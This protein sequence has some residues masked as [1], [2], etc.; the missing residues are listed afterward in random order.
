MSRLHGQ[1]FW[2]TYSVEH[3][4]RRPETIVTWCTISDD[5]QRKCHS[6][7]MANERDQIKVGYETV[8]IT[9]K[10]ATNKEEC[11][12]LLDQES[13]TMVTL[14]AGSVFVGGR[15][16]SLVPIAE[17][18]LDGGHNYYFSVAVIKKGSLDDVV[19][20]HQ[21]RGKKAC[22]PGVETFAGW[23]VP[24]NTLMKEG[25][26]E[27]VDCNN[28][29]KSAT[30]YFGPSCSVNCLSDKY[31][32]IGDNSDKL[33][34]LCIGK[35]PGGRCTDADPYAGYEGAF[36]C[37]LEAGEIA[38]L[39]HNSVP[40]IIEKLGFTGLS[41]DS[42]EL[43]CKDGSR[44][45]ISDYLAC[46]WGKV[47][48]DAVVVSSATS[49]EIRTKLQKFLEKFSKKYPKAHSNITYTST[50]PSNFPYGGNQYNQQQYDQFGNRINR[51]K[52]QDYGTNYGRDESTPDPFARDPYVLNPNQYGVNIDPYDRDVKYNTGDANRDPYDPYNRDP[53]YD[54]RDSNEYGGN[55]RTNGTFYEN[56]SLFESVPRYG[57]RSNL[58]FQD[59]ARH[60]APLPENLQT[61]SSFLGPAL[62]TIMGVRDCPVNRMILC[63]T[64]DAEK[65]KCVKMRTALKSQLLK[66]EM[67]CYKGHSQIHCMQAIRSG[68]ADVA[69]FDAGDIYTAGLNFEL[70]PFISEVY[71]LDEPEYYVVAVAKESDPSTELTYLKNKNTCHGGINTAAGWVYPLAF[72]I[73]NGWIRPYG[74]NS[75]RAAAEYFAKSCVPGAISTEYNTGVPYDNMCDLCHGAS[76]R[77]CRRDASEDYYGHTGA[78]RCLVEGGG[79]VAFV[80]HTTVTENTGG[81]KREWWARDNLNDDYELLCPDGTRAEI[82]E[83]KRCN[84]GKVKANAIIARGGYGYNETHINAYIN[85]FMYAQTL[86]GKKSTDEFSFSMYSSPAPY[87][88]LIFQDATTQLKMIEPYK[89]HYAEYLGSDFLRAKRVVDCHAG[90]IG[91]SLSVTTF[92]I[93]LVTFLL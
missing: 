18:V 82:H 28:H 33:C 14:D 61:F 52:R 93:C 58:L 59:A 22:F 84:L 38:F 78:F 89:R 88:D 80:K 10:Q 8:N 90:S 63:V 85:L 64:S 77:Y 31:N 20:L 25:G 70:V 69:V 30:N 42:F 75:I 49:F 43:L 62:D 32:P 53:Y 91:I 86:F 37:L 74:C 23:V 67:E 92:I 29:I 51:F 76:F 7:S 5:E 26:M 2:K 34:Q 87:S 27:I 68:T 35:I 54:G 19:S 17:E 79:H 81:K 4:P 16:H 50:T 1:N 60:I 44:R 47:P 24:I 36:K 57:D 3:R 46:N 39:K 15:Y 12:E 21:L 41:I 56:F 83:Y 45:P 71:N 65:N 73:S 72:L 11:M 66:P 55:N 9:C 48:S 40:E 6:F 13:A